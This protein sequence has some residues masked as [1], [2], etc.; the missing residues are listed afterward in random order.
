MTG[1]CRVWICGGLEGRFL[2]LPG[3]RREHE[4][5][6]A[7]L[8]KLLLMPVMQDVSSSQISVGPCSWKVA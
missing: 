1:G 5:A 4:A 6:R 3:L 8:I 7:V 2:R